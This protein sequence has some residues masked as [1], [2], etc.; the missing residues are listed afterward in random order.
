MAKS[1]WS[2]NPSA[3]EGVIEEDL[4]KR[5]TTISLD[6]HRNIV[7]RTPVDTGTAKRS[8]VISYGD[9]LTAAYKKP[10]KKPESLNPAQA[11][12]AEQEAITKGYQ[13]LLPK[14]TS[15][16]E[17]VVISSNLPYMEKLE[18][19]SSKQAPKGMIAVT[20]VG[21]NAKYNK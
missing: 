11:A 8:W 4:A 19:G 7:L 6:A 10:K 17:K 14:A 9:A 2:I 21:I 1:S 13:Q 15:P 12:A 5:R 16:Y 3:F 20:V 18:K